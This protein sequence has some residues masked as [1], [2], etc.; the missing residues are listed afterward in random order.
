MLEQLLTSRTRVRILSLLMFN[1]D[2]DY[3]LREIAR[4]ID[5]SPIYVGKELNNLLKLNLVNK[6]KKGNLS[7]YSINKKKLISQK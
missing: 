6:S 1:Q 7:I 3:H 2:R 5:I 4:L